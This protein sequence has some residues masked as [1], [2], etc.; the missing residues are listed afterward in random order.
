MQVRTRFAPSPTGYLHLGGLRTALYTY[1]FARKEGGKFILRIEDTDQERE[2]PGAIEK[3]YSS[4]RAAGLTYD[5]GPDVGGDYGP[6][7]QSQRRDTYLP[8]AKKLVESGHAYYCFCT[9]ERLDEARAEA[10]REGRTFKYDKHC[11]H[12]PKEEI[13]RRL[14]AGEPYVIR[15]NVPTEGRAG[16]DDVLYG[17]VE[18]DCS[19]LDDNVL[20]K[21]DGLP[22]YNFAN[23]I[24]DHLMGITHVMRGTEYLSS[25]PKYNLLYEAF[26]WQPPLYVHLPVVMRDQTRKLSKRYGDP[27]FEDLLEMGYLKEAIINFI[28]LLG[29]SPRSEREFFT[30]K[31]LEECF[32]LEGLN[33]SPSIFDMDKLTWFNAEY[34][35]KLSFEE[36][37][38]KA[39]PWLVRALGEDKF[40]LRRIAELLHN[41]TEVLNRI[42]E[43]V[44]FL[45]QMPQFENELYTHKKMKTNPDIARSALNGIRPVLEGVEEW[46]EA[47][48]HDRVMEAIAQSGMKNGQV[49]W[50]LRIAISGKASTPGGAIEIAYL[51]GKEETLRRLDQSIANLG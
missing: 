13:Q 40:D 15:Q 10:E 41:R 29:W 1:L 7:I 45:A 9:K 6:Y 3:I 50:P 21:A 5:E 19:T 51:L 22:T 27:S 14:E 36:F 33:K 37:Y 49:L 44:D 39:R 30:L 2:V 46:T 38:E 34:M 24:D 42:P 11:L 16:F 23:V 26:G 43:M 20:I 32:D 8:F 47:V 28:A 35:R 17:R 4:M 18:V 25:A 31:E 12:M 48:L